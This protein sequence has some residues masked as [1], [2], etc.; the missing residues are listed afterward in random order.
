MACYY[1]RFSRCSYSSCICLLK[2]RARA[3]KN[4]EKSLD[5]GERKVVK[6]P[7][8]FEVVSSRQLRYLGMVRYL[9]LSAA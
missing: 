2:L 5:G 7:I 8:T 9:R 3:C 6:V 1:L 4:E